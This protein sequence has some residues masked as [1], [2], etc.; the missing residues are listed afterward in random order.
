MLPHQGPRPL[1]AHA[2][3]RA[4]TK[5]QALGWLRLSMDR[6]IRPHLERIWTSNEI[7]EAVN[8]SRNVCFRRTNL[9]A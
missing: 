2:C 4:H 7:R 9:G 5:F 3:C 1:H 8:L 6:S